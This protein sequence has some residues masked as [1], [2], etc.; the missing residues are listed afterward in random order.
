M[1]RCW[2]VAGRE[3]PWHGA[4]DK[5]PRRYRPIRGA[6]RAAHGAA[7]PAL[8]KAASVSPADQRGL[9]LGTRFPRA[10]HGHARAEWT[11][12]PRGNFFKSLL[13]LRITLWMLRPDRKPHIAQGLELLA[14]CAFVQ[15]DAEH[16]LDASLEIG[17]PP[18]HHAIFFSI[19]AFLHKSGKFGFLLCREPGSPA[20]RLAIFQ[21]R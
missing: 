18:P 12:S 8:P 14:N 20:R 6:D 3:Q 1:L 19:R 4:P 10:C 5:P 7:I 13:G 16:L 17:A 21:P 2:H 15:P 9:R 11:R